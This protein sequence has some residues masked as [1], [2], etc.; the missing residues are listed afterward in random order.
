VDILSPVVEMRH[1]IAVEKLM[2]MGQEGTFCYKHEL[3]KASDKNFLL[4]DDQTEL[5]VNMDFITD[6]YPELSKH[7]WVYIRM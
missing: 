2:D 4:A 6:L 5:K 7:F 3:S 1:K